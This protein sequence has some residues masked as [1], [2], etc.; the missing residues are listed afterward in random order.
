MNLRHSNKNSMRR[1]P[2]LVKVTLHGMAFDCP[3]WA[4]G[5]TRQIM[6]TT[7]RSPD[8]QRVTARTRTTARRASSRRGFV[9]P[10]KRAGDRATPS[11]GICTSFETSR[12]QSLASLARA[13]STHRRHS[14][15]KAQ[16]DWATSIIAGNLCVLAEPIAQ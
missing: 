1:S 9:A 13:V 6:G 3:A 14:R 7:D 12:A 16:I 4:L 15:E 10:G 5:T 8:P 11:V 2:N